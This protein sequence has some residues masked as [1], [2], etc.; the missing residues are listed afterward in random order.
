MRKSEL[1]SLQSK[2]KA[3]AEQACGLNR[4]IQAASGPIRAQLRY[5]KKCLGYETRNL[6]L[7]YAFL[8][9]MPYKAAEPAC[10]DKPSVRGIKRVVQE[11]LPHSSADIDDRIS[12]WLDGTSSEATS[13]A[14]IPAESSVKVSN[15]AAPNV[16]LL[17]RVRSALRSVVG[18]G[19]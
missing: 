1:Q 14:P 16:S 5:E 9:G 11:E 2:I 6:L 19:L 12:S 7:A 15:P 4:D 18:S 10:S 8:R 3:N 17:G 13:D